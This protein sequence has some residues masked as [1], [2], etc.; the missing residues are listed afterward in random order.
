MEPG[1]GPLE[2]LAVNP[3][4][5]QDR[6]VLLTGHTGFKGA[7]LGLLLR[8]LGA[9][10]T[11]YALPPATEPS[12]CVD[13]DLPALLDGRLG[14]INTP[15][16]LQSLVT[17]VQPQVVLHLAAQALVSESYVDPLATWETNVLGTA[18]LLDALRH[19]Q[20]PCVVVVVTTDKCYENQEW[21]WG[22]RETDT[23]GGKDVYSASKAC[24]EL[25]TAACRQSF[26]ADRPVVIATARAGN[27]IGGGD[28]S[29]HRLVPDLIRAFH[30]GQSALIRSPT[31]VRPWQHVLEPL[32][33]YLRL[34]ECCAADPAFGKAWNFGPAVEDC[35]PVQ[36]VADRLVSLWGPGAGWHTEGDNPVKESH[37]LRLD[38]SLARQQLGWTPRTDL[39]AALRLTVDWYRAWASGADLR[40][41]TVGQIDDYLA[42]DP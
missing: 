6:R 35:W 13:L 11:G 41:V 1:S 20:G 37:A 15:G 7:W 39:A 32:A 25:V 42:G 17:D 2:G 4:F 19:L 26:F 14:N 9:R 22:Y 36:A 21:A 12:L 30:G 3:A 40:A 29:A 38:S 10:V 5:W 27:V 24:A 18:R 31:S 16:A 34:A 33:G 28:W 23:L 8:R